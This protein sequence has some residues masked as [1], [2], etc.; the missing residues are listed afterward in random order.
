[1]FQLTVGCWYIHFLHYFGSPIF[2]LILYIKGVRRQAP[3]RESMGSRADKT[4]N[5]QTHSQILVFPDHPCTP[6]DSLINLHYV[7]QISKRNSHICRRTLYNSHALSF[8]HEHWSCT[9]LSSNSHP[10]IC[11]FYIDCT[12]EIKYI[13][14]TLM[15]VRLTRGLLNMKQL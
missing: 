7:Y 3:D 15:P 6:I 4:D 5:V 13:Y 10:S 8:D 2:P 1:M 9:K 12:A 11:M 14:P